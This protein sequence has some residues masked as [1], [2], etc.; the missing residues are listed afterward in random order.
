MEKELKKK[1]IIISQYQDKITELSHRVAGDNERVRLMGRM[2]QEIE[3]LQENKMKQYEMPEERFSQN[4]SFAT[5]QMNS[6]TKKGSRPQGVG[7]YNDLPM[8]HIYS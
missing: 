8:S 4:Q 3:R 6:P 5:L 1:E 7:S 2:K